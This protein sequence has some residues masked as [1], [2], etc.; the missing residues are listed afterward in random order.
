MIYVALLRGINVGGK[1][2]MKMAAL[3]ECCE[4]AGLER[5]ATYIQSGNLIFETNGLS[6]SALTGR[7]ERALSKTF[8]YEA[9]VVIRSH[10][11]FKGV[12]AGAPSYWS[13]GDHLRR[14]VAFLRAPVTAKQ[15]LKEVEVKEGVDRVSAGK[16]VLYMSTL[17]SGLT[18]SGFTKLVSKQVYQDM[19]IRNYSTCFKILELMEERSLRLDVG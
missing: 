8:G 3:R 18:K 11:Q 6:A 10:S 19:T 13:S 12:I 9:A 5:V 1:R 2:V 4:H 17:L 15:A 7:I 16:G 14:Y